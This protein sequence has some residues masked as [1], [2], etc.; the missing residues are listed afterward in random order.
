MNNMRKIIFSLMSVICLF[1]LSSCAKGDGDKDYGVEKVYIPQAMADGGITNVYNVPSGEGEY[2]Y[3][4]A[5][6]EETV[7]VFLGVLRSGKQAGQAFSVDVVVNDE[8][9]AAQAAKLGA[10]VMNAGMYTLPEKVSV[11]AGTNSKTFNLSLNKAA[12]KEQAGKKLVLCVGLANCTAYEISEKAAEVT[13]LVNVD[14]LN[15]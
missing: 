5:I 11:A 15:L 2:T 12:L 7:E 1:A 13:V 8:T 6:K 14:A 9:S 3:N 4:F 10:E